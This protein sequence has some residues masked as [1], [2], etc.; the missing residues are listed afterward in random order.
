M[1]TR[2]HLPKLYRGFFLLI[3]LWCISVNLV[4][5]YICST[6]TMIRPSS[7]TACPSERILSHHVHESAIPYSPNA[8]S[9]LR[10]VTYIMGDKRVMPRCATTGGLRVVHALRPFPVRVRAG[11]SK[12]TKDTQLS[13]SDAVPATHDR[14]SLRSLVHDAT[15][16]ATHASKEASTCVVDRE[17][18]RNFASL[19][20][21]CMESSLL[22]LAYC[23]STR[24]IRPSLSVVSCLL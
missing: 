7:E 12:I 24:H 23:R 10:C 19:R 17:N 15:C 5:F 4:V 1:P 2:G 20:L 11:L 8:S 3:Q 18:L 13:L 6:P 9:L 21:T 14:P 16:P 22:Q